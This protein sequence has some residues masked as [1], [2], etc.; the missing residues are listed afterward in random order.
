MVPT[1]NYLV[2]TFILFITVIYLVGGQ[3]PRL[4]Y[5]F[6]LQSPH[7][8]IYLIDDHL[9]TYINLFIWLVDTGHDTQHSYSV[10]IGGHVYLFFTYGHI[11]LFFW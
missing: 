11:Y 10:H 3:W 5:L 4:I 7:L 9:T 6:G 1:F 2:A 8:I